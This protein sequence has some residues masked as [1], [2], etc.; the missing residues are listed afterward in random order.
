M[1]EYQGKWSK[2]ECLQPF[3]PTMTDTEKIKTRLTTLEFKNDPDAPGL[4]R[5]EV[6]A[7]I[8]ALRIALEVLTELRR[9]TNYTLAPPS[10]MRLFND[11]SIALHDI[12][13]ALKGK[14]RE[15]PYGKVEQRAGQPLTSHA[16]G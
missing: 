6:E 9:R 10:E 1:N 3:K 15:N 14:E 12:A 5:K 13:E 16:T 11:C 8:D 7:V 2:R 4:E